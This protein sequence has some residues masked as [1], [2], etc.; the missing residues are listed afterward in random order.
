MKIPKTE[1]RAIFS[2]KFLIFLLFISILTNIVLISKLKYPDI[3][4]TIQ[5]ALLPAPKVVPTDHVRGTPNAKFIIIEYADFQCP[6]CAKM[7][8]A[9]KSVIK[10]TDTQWVFRHFPIAAHPLASK[11]AEASECAGDQ[12]KFW[13]YSDALFELKEPMAE[14]TFLKIAQD[15][16]LDWMAFSLCLSSGKYGSAVAAQHEGGVKNKITGT[17]TFYLNGKRFD[18]FVPLEDLRKLM[19]AVGK[20]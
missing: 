20:S 3:F 18:G 2:K 5:V 8:E 16:G 12:G 19:G 4:N 10:E 15:L 7:H 9:M 13:E 11:A 6:Y 14:G 1:Q 17:P